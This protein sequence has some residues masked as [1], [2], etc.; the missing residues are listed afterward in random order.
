MHFQRVHATMQ[1][2]KGIDRWSCMWSRSHQHTHMYT[3][4][5]HCR[6]KMYTVYRRA[7]HQIVHHQTGLVTHLALVRTN[8]GLSPAGHTSAQKDGD[9]TTLLPKLKAILGLRWECAW[10]IRSSHVNVP[11]FFFSDFSVFCKLF[12]FKIMKKNLIWYTRCMEIF[13]Y[14]YMFLAWSI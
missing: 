2:S 12:I 10:S 4:Q 8:G 7:G 5:T 11:S 14:Q 13:I 9:E 6:P 3:T 1:A